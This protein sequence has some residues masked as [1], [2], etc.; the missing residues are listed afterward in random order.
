MCLY[1][2]DREQLVIDPGAISIS[3]RNKKGKRYHFDKGKFIKKK[4]YL[5]ELRTDEAGR[6]I[7][8]GG[9]GD[10][11]SAFPNNSPTTFGNNDGWHD[12]TADGPVTATVKLKGSDDTL[13]VDPAWV[14][15][16][17]PN[18]APDVISVQTIWDVIFDAS[19]GQFFPQKT[20]PSFMNDI[21]PLLQQFSDAQWVNYGFYVNYGYQQPF[22][23]NNKD[24]IAKLATITTD[25][26]GVVDDRF[27][28]YRRQ[29]FNYFRPPNPTQIDADA[30]PWMYGDVVSIPATSPQAFLSVT[31]TL[32]TYLSNWKDGNFIQDWDPDFQPPS[33]IDQ[34][35]NPAKQAHLI[36]KAS[37]WFCLGGP[38]HPGC[39]MTWPVRHSTMYNSAFRFRIRAANDPEP[40]YGEM[41]DYETVMSAR[42]PLYAQGPGDITRWMAVPW[43]TDT[44]SCRS[45]YDSQYDPWVPTFWPAR[46]PNHVLAEVEY[47]KVIDESLP[48]EERIEAFNTRATWYRLLGP[49]ASVNQKANMVNRFG[50]LGVVEK[51]P[52]VPNSDE[53]PDVM[54]VESVPGKPRKRKNA[55]AEIDDI[56]YSTG[57]YVGLTDKVLPL[58]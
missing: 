52:G 24:Y 10:S 1:R 53:F 19:Q 9:Y 48:M 13:E 40:D 23:F 56:P 50:D 15:S 3:G 55:K 30:W 51:R 16:A 21:L 14:L 18:Y 34:V 57:R 54:Y 17:P 12:D 27:R 47:L 33:S 46:V 20:V 35:S 36:N 25:K 58:K 38:F 43:Q 28:E 45:G 49:S 41:L 29:I 6:L 8:L 39:E 2:N 7:F 4:V 22:D 5:G 11:A 31:K 44:A 42:G 32:H 37:L 26:D